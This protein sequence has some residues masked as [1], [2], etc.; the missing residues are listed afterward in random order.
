MPPADRV[1]EGQLP[2]ADLPAPST[3]PAS[4]EASTPMVQ[5][6]TLSLTPR[7]SWI[8]YARTMMSCKHPEA[9]RI[10]RKQCHTSDRTSMACR[11]RRL[12]VRRS[13]L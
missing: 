6:G 9:R 11:R 12:A 8:Q 10:S 5:A 4:T 1:P 13:G 7:L 3:V 2:A